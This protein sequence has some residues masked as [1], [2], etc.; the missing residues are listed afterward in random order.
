MRAWRG[1]RE[2][3]RFMEIARVFMSQ[4]WFCIVDDEGFTDGPGLGL[5]NAP[6]IS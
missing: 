2:R 3:E 4:D 6:N 5:E 1:E